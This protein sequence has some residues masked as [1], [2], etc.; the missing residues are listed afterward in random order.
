MPAARLR[1]TGR[2]RISVKVD[3]AIR[4]MAELAA[5]ERHDPLKADDIAARQNI[6]AP[7]L[8]SILTDLR[9]AQL[10]RSTRGRHG[11]YTLARA[12]E[13]ITLADVI[14]ALEGPLANIRDTSLRDLRYPGA[15]AALVTVWM[16]V[17]TGLRDVLE[18]VTLAHLIANDLPNHVGTM[19]RTYESEE[20]R[21]HGP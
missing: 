5:A 2:V 19:A 18:N 7:F 12:A 9:Q 4:A 6:P 3:Y 13:E 14:R 11:G 10:V 15:A 1:H 20:R 21:R 17:R 16:A 8:H